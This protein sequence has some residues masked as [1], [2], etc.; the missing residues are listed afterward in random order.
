MKLAIAADPGGA[1]RFT[2]TTLT[3][4]AGRVEIEFSN[5]SQLPHAVTITGNGVDASTKVV[6][7]ADAPPV[8][9]DLKPGTYTFFCPVDDHREE[10]MQGTLTVR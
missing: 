4:K 6:T 9:V 8:T 1:I 2:H 5:R 10:G 7:D 3:A